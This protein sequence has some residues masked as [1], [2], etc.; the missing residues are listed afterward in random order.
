MTDDL[1][2]IMKALVDY[3]EA[4]QEGNTSKAKKQENLIYNLRPNARISYEYGEAIYS[5]KD[6][7]GQ[8]VAQLRYTPSALKAMNV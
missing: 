4:Q 1:K 7:M 3:I 6:K 2:V 8:W 5:I